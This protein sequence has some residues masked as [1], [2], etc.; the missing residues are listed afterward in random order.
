V[1]VEPCHTRFSSI[2]KVHTNRLGTSPP[3]QD[4]SEPE[5][6][7]SL[8][9]VGTPSIV[10]PHERPPPVNSVPHVASSP[11]PPT[12]PDASPPESATR[13]G[14]GEEIEYLRAEVQNQLQTIAVLVSDKMALSGSLERLSGIS[15]SASSH[16]EIRDT[17]EH[18]N[19]SNG[20]GQKSGISSPR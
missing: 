8:P 10:S 12:Q 20:R 6:L 16:S 9:R 5:W 7:T 13:I 11:A 17:K 3:R 4:A 15:T 19:F 1:S 18:D 2:N 14:G